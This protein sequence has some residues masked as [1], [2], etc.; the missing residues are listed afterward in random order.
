MRFSTCVGVRQFHDGRFAGG[1][2]DCL[3]QYQKAGVRAVPQLFLGSVSKQ[4]I[5][6]DG[7]RLGRGLKNQRVVE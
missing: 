4:M 6:N 2:L 1:E 3:P 5:W 7:E